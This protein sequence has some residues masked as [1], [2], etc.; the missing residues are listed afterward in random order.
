M[1][2]LILISESHRLTIIRA[3]VDDS[4]EYLCEAEN[5]YSKS[6]SSVA[7]SVEGKKQIE[8]K[9]NL[10]FFCYI[11]LYSFIFYGFVIL[12]RMNLKN[13]NRSFDLK[14]VFFVWKMYKIKF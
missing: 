2:N 13:S 12:P 1:D 5:E 11:R 7:I 6:S 8:H 10:K 3:N 9:Y 14:I 4:G